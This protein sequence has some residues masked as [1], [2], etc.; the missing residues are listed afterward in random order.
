MGG[1]DMKITYLASLAILTLTTTAQA[2]PTVRADLEISEKQAAFA[3]A[4]R[5]LAAFATPPVSREVERL[6]RESESGIFSFDEQGRMTFGD[7]R[8]FQIALSEGEVFVVSRN[9]G[10][11]LPGEL[12]VNPVS[13]EA[14]EPI[15]GALS[16]PLPAAVWLLLAGLSGLGFAARR[17]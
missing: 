5:A 11:A 16:T 1:F 8:D 12:F 7:E 10:G 13:P 4:E 15:D 6:S 14:P 17:K 2:A 9:D 3:T